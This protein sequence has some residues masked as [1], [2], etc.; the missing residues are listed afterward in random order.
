M[1]ITT[2]VTHYKDRDADEIPKKVL[3]NKQYFKVGCGGSFL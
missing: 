1:Y 2:L 3:K